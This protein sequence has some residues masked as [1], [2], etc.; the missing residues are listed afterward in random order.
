VAR[1]VNQL[2]CGLVEIA[3]WAG[4]YD[5]KPTTSFS[6]KKRK[7]NK[8]TKQFEETPFLNVSDLPNIIVA[9]QSMLIDYY[10]SLQNNSATTQ[11]P[12]DEVPF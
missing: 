8:E 5:G 9:C 7:F 1:P 2:K 3:Q 12:Q 4:S 11:T 6:L 10:K